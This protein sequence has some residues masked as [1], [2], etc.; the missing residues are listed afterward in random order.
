[1]NT[2]QQQKQLEL[3]LE[4]ASGFRGDYS[5]ETTVGRTASSLPARRS[6]ATGNCSL[7]RVFLKA[8]RDKS[9]FWSQS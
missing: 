1:M 2:L 5:S 6:A 7:R 3:N 9:G 4:G 8:R